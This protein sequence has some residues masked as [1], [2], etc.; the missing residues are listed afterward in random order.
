MTTRAVNLYKSQIDQMIGTIRSRQ[1]AAE[2][3]DDLVTVADCEARIN[4]LL[5]ARK[6]CRP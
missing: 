5:D 2:A 6:F 4:R 1:R 3:L